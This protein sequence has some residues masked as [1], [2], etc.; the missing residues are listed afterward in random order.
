ME[1]QEFDDARDRLVKAGFHCRE[2]DAAWN[3]FSTLRSLY[4]SPLNELARRMAI[5]PAK[6]IGD[7]SYLPHS[8]RAGR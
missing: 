1:R 8:Q 6:W 2:G 3:E 4:A 5:I 7:R